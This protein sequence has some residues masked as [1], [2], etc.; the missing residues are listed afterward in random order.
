[1][2]ILLSLML[3]A[4]LAAC[5]STP[6]ARYLQADEVTA[7]DYKTFTLEKIDAK[8][9]NPDAML[10][11]GKAIKF[12]LESRGMTY[13]KENAELLIEFGVGIK[14]V[15]E[16]QLKV[17]PIGGATYTGHTLQNNQYGT[18]I[19]NIS[20]ALKTKPIWYMSGSRKIENM[21]RSQ[22]EINQDF[23]G[24]LSNFK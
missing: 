16:V 8:G 4:F 11:A 20:D 5:S 9:L 13:Q 3:T 21:N 17:V 15:N 1:M 18:L 14:Q 10:V 12:A 24:I 23:I 7:A 2:K 19:I 22:E 6:N